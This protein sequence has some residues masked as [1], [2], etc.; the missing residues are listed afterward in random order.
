MAKYNIS[1]DDLTPNNLQV[2]R[3]INSVV[4]PLPYSDAWYKESLT[5]GPLVKLAF[6][7]EIPVGAIRCS[8]VV[9]QKHNVGE[10]KIYIMTLAVLAPYRRYGIGKQ[11]VD[12]IINDVVKLEEMAFVK[13]V[14]CH[15]WVENTDALEWYVK[16]AGFEKGE[17]VPGYYKKMDP[18]GDAV[19]LRKRV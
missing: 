11:L 7:N 14:Y 15:V 3:R 16:T 13:E 1:L 17:V 12:Y 19:V 9:P 10:S 8:L 2:L 5:V 4:L 6:F 18:P